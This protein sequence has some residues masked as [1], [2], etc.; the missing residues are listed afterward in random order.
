MASII[1]QKEDVIKRGQ[2]KKEKVQNDLKP[3]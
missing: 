2:G 1:C 3:M